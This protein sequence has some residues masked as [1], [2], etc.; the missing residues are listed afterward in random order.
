MPNDKSETAKPMKLKGWIGHKSW[1]QKPFNVVNP[2]GR[3]FGLLYTTKK[4]AMLAGWSHPK[5]VQITLEVL[6]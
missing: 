6:S 2:N 4:E 3:Q 5:R 1:L